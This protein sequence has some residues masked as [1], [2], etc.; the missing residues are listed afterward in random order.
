MAR[1]A[2]ALLA[3]GERELV[4]V[5]PPAGSAAQMFERLARDPSVDV[6]KLERLIAMQERINAH[7]A[8][9]AFDTAF[10]EMQGEIPSIVERGSTNNG[11]Y[12]EL[13]DIVAAVRPVLQKHGFSLSHET[14]WPD[15]KTVKVIGILTHK[16]GHEKRTEFLSTADT[17]G[18][19]NAIQGLGSA[20]SYGRRY[21]TK[22]LLC[23]VTKGEDDDATK[24]G[25][26]KQAEAPAGF[27]AWW[28]DF[29][30]AAD[31]GMPAL[32][33]TWKASKKEFK[34]YASATKRNEMNA[35]KAKASRVAA[36]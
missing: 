28:D 19:K 33:S 30:A 29:T 11:R 25:A 20:V 14:Q 5:D 16:Q 18:N 3:H 27:E 2:G 12:A 15:A 32:E 10:A 8:K 22:D 6:E 34:D 24:A 7:M 13:E 9:S 1:E 4:T 35:L 17:S 26:K 21:T 36:S 23:I 31:N